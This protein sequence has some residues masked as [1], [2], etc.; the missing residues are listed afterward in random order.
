MGYNCQSQRRKR[1]LS[2]STKA[3]IIAIVFFLTA[4]MLS[5][6]NA[7]EF[8]QWVTKDGEFAMTEDPDRIPEEYRGQAVKRDFSDI[9]LKITKMIS[10]EEE[11]RVKLKNR[12]DRFR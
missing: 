9:D 2:S 8:Y 4:C 11:L 10:S 5:D 3:S 12:L 6:A 7:G 1:T